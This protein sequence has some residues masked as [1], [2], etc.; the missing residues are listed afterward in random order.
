MYGAPPPSANLWVGDLPAHIDKTML[1]QLF[2]PYGQ[3]VDCKVLSGTGVKASAMVMFAAVEIAAWV[4]ENLNGNIP[5]ALSEPIIVRYANTP[6]SPGAVARSTPYSSTNFA[7]PLPSDNV[8]VGDLPIGTDKI[9][10]ALIFESWGQII[11]SRML[12]GRDELSKPCAM[13]RFSSVDVASAVVQNLD[14]K[15]PEGLLEPIIVRFANAPRGKGGGQVAS[16]G[17][18]GNSFGP[19]AIAD[20]A[21]GLM[22][23]QAGGLLR[24]GVSSASRGVFVPPP[25]T[26]LGKAAGKSVGK[27]GVP[28]SFNA[29]YQSVKKAGVLGGGIVPPECSV[30]IKNI[31]ADT[32]DLDLYKLFSPFGAIPTTGVKAMINPDGTCKGFGF[33][34]F[35]EPEAA[36][37]AVM[38]LDGHTLPD[39]SSIGVSCKKP[40]MKV[41]PP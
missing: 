25:V 5:E 9:Q 30:F 12:P 36:A 27:A 21:G 41:Q 24:A 37:N 31:P 23:D 4:C 40:S 8:W 34:D 10:L 35:A 26:G 7:P 1:L 38:S 17:L 19:A 3:V 32:T 2:E 16:A 6:R 22:P 33:V 14:G 20:N 18:A 39:G 29:I 13:I 28:G 15:I 11:E